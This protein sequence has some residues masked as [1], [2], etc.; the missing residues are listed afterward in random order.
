MSDR[1]ADGIP[2]LA[3]I[4]A[5]YLGWAPHTFWSATPLE[6]VLHLTDPAAGPARGMDRSD[7]AR[8]MEQ[9]T[10]G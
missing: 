7:L 8:M 1:L 6:L 9:E 5:Q 10:N 2:H 3:G 4:A